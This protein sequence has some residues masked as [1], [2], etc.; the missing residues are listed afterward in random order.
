[1]DFLF[2]ESCHSV[3]IPLLTR[4][5]YCHLQPTPSII[6]W[7]WDIVCLRY[8]HFFS[9]ALKINI[10]ENV[11]RLEGLEILLETRNDKGEDGKT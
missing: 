7:A 1:M 2:R 10:Y 8:L 4:L 5:F 11:E 6:I 9:S 3:P